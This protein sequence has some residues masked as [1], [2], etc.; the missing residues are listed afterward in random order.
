MPGSKIGLATLARSDKAALRWASADVVWFGDGINRDSNMPEDQNKYLKWEEPK[1]KDSSQ[2]YEDGSNWLAY[3]E[4]LS[5]SELTITTD[6]NESGD[7]ITGFE[8]SNTSDGEDFFENDS[9]AFAVMYS[10]QDCD[11]TEIFHM[12]L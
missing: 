10:C 9:A 1:V 12:L 7:L 5:N 8:F 6:I 11:S 2:T 4:T 3:K